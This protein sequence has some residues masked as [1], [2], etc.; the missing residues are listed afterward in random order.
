M[1]SDLLLDSL[2]DKNLLD[3]VQDRKTLMFIGSEIPDWV[4]NSRLVCGLGWR[5]KDAGLKNSDV[6]Q[7]NFCYTRGKISRQRVIDSGIAIP[8]DLPIGD[9]G[10]LASLLYKPT[11]EKKHDI[12]LITHWS[13][14]PRLEQYLNI[15]KKRFPDKDIAIM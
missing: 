10:L 11:S 13:A 4:D 15:A 9:S 5:V 1:F 7:D 6:N 12:G 8:S 3:R 2:Y 14:K